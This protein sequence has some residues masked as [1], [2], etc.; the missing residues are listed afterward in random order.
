MSSDDDPDST[1]RLDET[2]DEVFQQFQSSHSAQGNCV[3]GQNTFGG[4]D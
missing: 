2:I 1:R 4:Q 3:T